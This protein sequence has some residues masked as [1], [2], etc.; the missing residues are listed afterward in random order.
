M[1]G[2]HRVLREAD[3][4]RSVWRLSYDT[5]WKGFSRSAREVMAALKKQN[6]E[7][8]DVVLIGYSMGGIVARQMIAYGFPARSV[9][10]LCSPH[11]GALGWSLLRFPIL[12]DPG[13]STLTQWSRSL[14]RL[15]AH[16]RDIAARKNYHLMSITFRDKRG[17]HEHD[18]IV[19]QKSAEGELL[20]DVAS[21]THLRFDYGRRAFFTDP[22]MLGMSP[23]AVA[24]MRER[25]EAILHDR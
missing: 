14:H 8:D 10:T 5:H 20:G 12:S 17:E 22:H 4:D 13:A 3:P 16:P 19:G 24:P 15:N 7:G 9:V 2:W 6:L 18:G 25:I 11:H 21:R 1:R 23:N